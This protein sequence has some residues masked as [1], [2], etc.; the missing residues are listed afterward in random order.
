M[1]SN[2]LLGCSFS[3]GVSLKKKVY[4]RKK[5]ARIDG[6]SVIALNLYG[7]MVVSLASTFVKANLVG[8]TKQ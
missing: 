6:V 5:R 2:R 7:N 3:S 4:K 8:Q 1:L